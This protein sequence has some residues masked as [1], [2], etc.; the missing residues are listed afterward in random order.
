MLRRVRYSEVHWGLLLA[1]LLLTGIGLAFVSSATSDP[2]DGGLG[3]EARLQIA[4]LGIALTTCLVCL[5]V[6]TTT[7]QRLAVPA[8]IAA[9]LIQS[10]MIALAGSPLVPTIKGAHNWIALGPARVQPSEFYK[11]AALLIGAHLL[12]RPSTDVR[13][14]TTCGLLIG[15]ICLPALLIARED[16]GSAMTF[17]PMAFGQLFLAGMHLRH[18]LLF[19]AGGIGTLALA[20]WSLPADSYQYRRLLAWLDPEQY[21]LTTG[22]QTLRALRSI[23]SGQLTG[24]GYAAGDQNLLGW[25]PEKHTDMIFAVIAEETG[26]LGCLVVLGLILLWG[27]VGLFTAMRCRSAFARFLVGGF[28]CLIIGQVTIN[29][30]V[31]LGLMPVTGITL[32]FFSYGG[33]SLLGCYIG[34][35]LCLSASLARNRQLGRRSQAL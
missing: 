11:L 10:G 18:L 6:P 2:V 5:H 29:L 4:W 13:H 28:T 14:L 33:S 23:G 30:L 25:L 1:S 17:V 15:I 3:R 34:I 8:F 7:W 32:P 22:F 24:K 31:V 26:F 9:L 21:A 27:W 16:L 12:S 35:G 19:G 20:I